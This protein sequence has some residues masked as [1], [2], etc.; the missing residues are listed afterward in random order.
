MNSFIPRKICIDRADGVEELLVNRGIPRQVNRTC[1]LIPNPAEQSSR[2]QLTIEQITIK[3]RLQKRIAEI[4]DNFVDLRWK[5]WIPNQ[6][7]DKV[8]GFLAA[9]KI[10]D[11]D[12]WVLIK[13]FQDK[14]HTW[15]RAW[16]GTRGTLG[17]KYLRKRKRDCAGEKC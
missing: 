16:I 13:R 1:R 2:N 5:H 4:H 8:M 15:K 9:G 11:S 6:G 14:L 3:H 12:S 7:P 17:V 10:S